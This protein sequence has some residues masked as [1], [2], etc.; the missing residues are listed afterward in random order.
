[1]VHIQCQPDDN[2]QHCQGK[3]FWLVIL[4]RLSLCEAHGKSGSVAKRKEH[5]ME[6]KVEW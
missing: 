4:A 2:Q 1:M 6:I 3:G 5:E